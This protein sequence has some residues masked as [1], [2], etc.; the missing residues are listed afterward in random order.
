MILS[1]RLKNFFSPRDE[2]VLDFTADRSAA[3]TQDYL[4]ENLIEFSGDKFVNIIGLFG[5]NAAGK[6]NIIKAIDFCRKLILTSHLNNEGDVFDFEAFKFLP[7]QPSEFYIN[8]VTE[9]KE[10][11][12]SF[13]L[14]SEKII[15]EN[16]YHY[17]NKRRARIFRERIHI[18]LYMEKGRCRGLLR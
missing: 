14:D 12:Y 16:L 6:S 1:L 11:E 4:P 7:D 13:V 3:K 17:P 18:H 10:Y 5:S 15:S 2:A 9:G 8:F